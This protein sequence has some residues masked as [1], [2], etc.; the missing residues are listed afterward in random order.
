M[1]SQS[2]RDAKIRDR[3]YR[4]WLSQGRPDGHDTAHWQQA[5]REIEAEEA[6]SAGGK[7]APARPARPKRPRSPARPARRP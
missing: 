1:Q 4:I 7:P 3:A 5:Q 2:D 6:G